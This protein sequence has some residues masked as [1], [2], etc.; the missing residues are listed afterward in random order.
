MRL[1]IF[2][3]C[4]TITNFQTAN[5]FCKF[6]LKKESRYVFIILDKLFEILFVYRVLAKLGFSGWL[7][8]KKFLLRALKGLNIGKLDMYGFQYIEEMVE[9]NLNEEVYNLFLHHIKNGDIVV[10]DVCTIGLSVDHRA[11]DGV[12]A[13]KYLQFLKTIIENPLMLSL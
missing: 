9:N 4:D 6:V 2:D 12:A 1:V 3:F 8:Q 11:I 5:E 13:A 7:S 10:D